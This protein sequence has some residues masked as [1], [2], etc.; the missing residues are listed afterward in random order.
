MDRTN[1][2]LDDSIAGRK[3]EIAVKLGRIRAALDRNELDGLFIQKSNNFAWITAGGNN[4]VTRYVENGIAGILV[5]RGEAY[6]LTNSI[7]EPRMIDE[8]AIDQLGFKI[9]SQNWFE[10]RQ[11]EQIFD[12]VGKNGK[13]GSD[14]PLS[15][16]ADANELISSLHRVF[17]E[18]EI[19]RYLHMG[20]MYSEVIESFMHTVRPGD[21]EIKIAGRLGAAMWENGLDPVL[22][23]VCADERIYKYRHGIPT[24][25]KLDKYLM[26]SCNCRYKGMV[27]KITRSLYFGKTPNELQKQY[28]Q[29]LEIEN[30]LACLTQPGV[31]D[32]E[33]LNMARSMYESFSYKDMWTAHHQ[34]GPQGYTNGYYLI[35]PQCH[36][37]IQKNQVYGYNPSITGTKTEDAFIVTGE[38][39]LYVTYPVSFPKIECETGGYTFVRPGILEM[40]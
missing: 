14:V 4:I 8:E 2:A 27:T 10:N 3:Q 28:L 23:L 32:I 1:Y 5:T 25:K 31:D 29:T 24:M 33:A 26:V 22:Y 16:A 12:I 40:A 35:S 7:E 30:T 39:P 34:G 13:V 18:S 9:V 15:Y 6:C 17:L 21:S 36:S 20:D 37:I 19:A 11:Q 38:K